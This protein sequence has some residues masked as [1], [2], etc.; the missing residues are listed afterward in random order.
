MTKKISDCSLKETKLSLTQQER[1]YNEKKKNSQMKENPMAQNKATDNS[2][3][4]T[5]R[6]MI[7]FP[8][9]EHLN[10]AMALIIMPEVTVK[11]EQKQ[12]K[13]TKI[14][15]LV[16]A[17]S[18]ASSSSSLDQ[19]FLGTEL[20]EENEDQNLTPHE[21]TAL[22][23]TCIP[24]LPIEIAVICLIFNILLPGLGKYNKIYK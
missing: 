23:Q 22:F 13:D 19:R 7:H 10:G 17:L 18:V 20:K 21:S 2:T 4:S 15:R 6:E 14:S 3:D 16:S 11:E 12:D 24:Y 9:K 8:G 5:K 1:N